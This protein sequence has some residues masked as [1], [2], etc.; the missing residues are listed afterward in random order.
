MRAEIATLKVQ[1]ADLQESLARTPSKKTVQ[2]LEV[3]E[4]QTHQNLYRDA[5]R[6]V[7]LQPGSPGTPA[8]E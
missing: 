6:F 5:C 7:K 2:E 4:E 8:D 3:Q 1:I